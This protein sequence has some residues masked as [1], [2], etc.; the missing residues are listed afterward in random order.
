[1][2]SFRIRSSAVRLGIFISTVIIATILVFQLAWLKKV[3]RFEEKE[4]DHSVLKSIRGLYEDL[5]LSSY[6]SSHLSELIEKPA[7]HLYLAHINLPVN[8]DTLSSYLQYELEDFDIFTNC[9]FAIYN[10]AEKKYIYSN[11]LTS[12]GAKETVNKLPLL[13]DRDY[14]YIALNFP[15][16]RQYI[17]SQMNFWITSSAVLLVVLLLFGASLYYFYR[18]KFLNETQKDF[19]H[20][21][22]HEFKTPVTV[23]S[24]AADVLKD[25]TISSRPEK[26][27]TYAGIVENQA[28][29][30]HHQIEKLLQFANTESGHLHLDIQEVDIHDLVKEAVHNLAPLIS[31]KKARLEYDL[32][33]MPPVL[34]AD[35][36]YLLIVITNLLDNAIKY[37][38][39]PVI[40]ISTVTTTRSLLLSVKDNG[41]GIEQNELKKLFRKFYRVRRGDTYTTKGFGIG[42]SFVKKILDTHNGKIK[43]ET[44]PGE[45]SIFI[46][47]LPFH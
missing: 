38:R 6:T 36:D 31:E 11:L 32:Q 45:G 40:R 13:F 15:N 28:H 1:M 35:R 26:L 30:L 29:Y 8:P 47:E 34:R 3:Y 7:R 24:L 20:N 2:S 44:K 12:A 27:S 39:E 21:F 9:Q 42:L 17:L 23:I 14:D 43:I 4:F 5:E 18:Q 22:T 16:R 19:I 10:H 33:A 37:A 46:I 25:D 41:I